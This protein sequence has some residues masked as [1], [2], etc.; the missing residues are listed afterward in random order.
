MLFVVF[1]CI[2][3]A[4]CIKLFVVLNPYYLQIEEFLYIK[5]HKTLLSPFLLQTYYQGFHTR[6]LKLCRIF[7]MVGFAL[8]TTY[9]RYHQ[10]LIWTKELYR[11]F[12]C[13]LKIMK[14]E[15]S[16]ALFISCY[17]YMKIVCISSYSGLDFPHS[18]WIWRDI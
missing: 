3:S 11:W 7:D 18:N 13:S 1:Y 12:I 8:N 17:H 4:C 2:K 14:K 5:F 10:R 9:H 6:E 15:H 16:K